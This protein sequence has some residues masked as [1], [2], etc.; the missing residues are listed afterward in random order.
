MRFVADIQAKFFDDC[1]SGHEICLWVQ[2]CEE[3]LKKVSV[4]MTELMPQDEVV[5]TNEDNEKYNVIVESVQ[6]DGTI[7]IYDEGLSP[8]Q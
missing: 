7:T 5:Y 2:H 8:Q 6:D 3:S 4:P 1:W